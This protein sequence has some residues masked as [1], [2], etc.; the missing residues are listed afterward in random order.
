MTDSNTPPQEPTPPQNSGDFT[1]GEGSSTTDGAPRPGGAAFAAPPAS[2]GAGAT[3]KTSPAIISLIVVVALLAIALIIALIRPWDN[4]SSN[5]PTT[6]STTPIGSPT[7]SS[8]TSTTATEELTDLQVAEAKIA[9]EKG[10]VAGTDYVPSLLSPGWELALSIDEEGDTGLVRGPAD[11]PV[12]VHVFGD[13]SCPLCTRLHTES[14]DKLEEMADEG[15]IRLEWHNFVIFG[16]YGSDKAARGTIAAAK[17]DKLWEF[18][19]AAYDSAGDGNHPTYTDESVEEIAKQAG[20]PD[21]DQFRND[22]ASDETQ[23][24]VTSQTDYARNT[25]G[26]T[27]TP[28]LIVRGSF[29]NGAYPTDIILNT[30]EMQTELAARGF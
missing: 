12:T 15:K 24:A 9:D 29:I 8:S 23:Q 27:G 17:Q 5:G 10:W 6:A 16:D 28:N 1:A 18:I 14:M 22:Y 4:T 30:I 21:M 13:F 26:L 3:R 11:A 19:A 7:E 2:P 25:L 20:I